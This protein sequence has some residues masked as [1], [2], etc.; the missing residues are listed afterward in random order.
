MLT[1]NDSIMS[2][3]YMVTLSDDDA[4]WMSRHP[5]LKLSKLAKMAIDFYKEKLGEK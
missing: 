3:K 2:K 5:E 4:A 1:Y